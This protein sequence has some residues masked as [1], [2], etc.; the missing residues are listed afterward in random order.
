MHPKVLIGNWADEH[1]LYDSHSWR[2][3]YHQATSHKCSSQ[4][5]RKSLQDTSDCSRWLGNWCDIGNELD[6]GS[7]GVVGHCFS[8]HVVGFS[9]PWYC[10][11]PTVI[12][13]KNNSLA[14]SCHCPEAGRHLCC[15]WVF[16]CV[17]WW[18][19]WHATRS[20]RGVHH[21]STSWHNTYL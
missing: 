3:H 7:Q 6:E 18:F 20:I 11:S 9:R 1:T 12:I 16:K 4:P 15:M 21:W 5:S 10:C 8:H 14:S 19:T 17:W 2:E 13:L